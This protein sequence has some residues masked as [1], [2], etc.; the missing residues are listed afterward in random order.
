MIH[1]ILMPVGNLATQDPSFLI[2]MMGITREP[3]PFFVVRVGTPLLPSVW[4][5]PFSAAQASLSDK[6]KPNS[7]LG[8]GGP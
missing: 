8:I 7:V 6:W 2:C 5:P 4:P 1:L 3:S